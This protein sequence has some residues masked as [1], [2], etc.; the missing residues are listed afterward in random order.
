M[1][2]S[3]ERML[4]ILESEFAQAA[5][6]RSSDVR[7]LLDYIAEL[8]RQNELYKQQV[9]GLLDKLIDTL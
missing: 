4:E 8:E 9:A 2:E 1:N 5:V 3:V 7:P 6:F